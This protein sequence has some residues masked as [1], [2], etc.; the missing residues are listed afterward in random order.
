VKEIFGLSIDP[1]QFQN[2]EVMGDGPMISGES[3]RR[4]RLF[5]PRYGESIG[6]NLTEISRGVLSGGEQLV[7]EI[8][9]DAQAEWEVIQGKSSKRIYEI[10]EHVFGPN[11]DE[12]ETIILDYDS[13]VSIKAPK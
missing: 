12:Q 3:T 2:G 5:E 1:A 13:P 9:R 4:L 7:I 11:I 10:K 6:R 8:Y